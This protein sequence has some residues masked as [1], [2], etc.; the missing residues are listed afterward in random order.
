MFIRAIRRQLHFLLHLLLIF[1]YI[2]HYAYKSKNGAISIT[3]IFLIYNRNHCVINIISVELEQAVNR[4]TIIY[5]VCKGDVIECVGPSQINSPPCLKITQS[6]W[7][8]VASDP[9]IS[10]AAIN[11]TRSRTSTRGVISGALVGRLP[12]RYIYWNQS[13]QSVLSN[14]ATILKT[15]GWFQACAQPMRDVVTL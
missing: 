7:A 9:I 6:V 11:S 14:M 13:K 5:P 12:Q 3:T 8:M 15:Q 2:N 4:F 10:E 1:L